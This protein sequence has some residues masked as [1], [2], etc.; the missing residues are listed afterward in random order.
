MKSSVIVFPG[1]NCD[2][3]VAVAL[4]KMNF[5]NQMVWHKETKLPKSDLIVLPGGFSYG[6]YL[7]SGSIAGKSLIIDEVIKAANDGCLILGICNGFQILTETGLLNGTLL[8]NKNLK[9]INKD[10]HIK[11]VDN[12][13][14]FTNKYKKNQVLEINIAHNEGNFFT[15]KNHL[16]E[17]QKNDLIAFKYCDAN[18]DINEQSNPNGSLKNIAGIYNSKKNILGMMPHPERMIDKLISNTDGVNLFSSLLN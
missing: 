9:F 15:D 14:K 2:R 5:K 3:D 11:V 18:G 12:K 10:I 1:S 7:R 17:L 6:D 16:E 13:T 8:R 4:E